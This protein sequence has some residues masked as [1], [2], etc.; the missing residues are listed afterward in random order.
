M[1]NWLGC[2]KSWFSFSQTH[3]V[4]N[5]SAV[6]IGGMGQMTYWVVRATE[7]SHT[8]GKTRL[9]GSDLLI[10][11]IPG[12]VYY[13]K[14]DRLYPTKESTPWKIKATPLRIPFDTTLK[15]T[16]KCGIGLIMDDS[17]VFWFISQLSLK[18]NILNL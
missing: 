1:C 4:W 3:P 15:G 8:S 5:K 12:I 14:W 2:F 18:F 9:N 7:M 6:F 10:F 13:K 16:D 11:F 17:G